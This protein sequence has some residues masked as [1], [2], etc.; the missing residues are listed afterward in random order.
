MRSATSGFPA[1]LLPSTFTISEQLNEAGLLGYANQIAAFWNANTGELQRRA[2]TEVFFD[3]PITLALQLQQAGDF[4]TALD[5]YRI[6]YALDLPPGNVPPEQLPAGAPPR[7]W[8]RIFP[9]LNAEKSIVTTYDQT[10]QWLLDNS[11]NP[12]QFAKQRA[13]AYTRFT[14]LA[15]VRCMLS[16]ADSE[17][18]T[19]SFESLPRAR[20][21]Y[22]NAREVLDMP[23][24]SLPPPD[25][26]VQMNPV[27]AAF[28]ANGRSKPF[29][30]AY[31]TQY[32]RHAAG[33][34]FAYCSAGNARLD[35]RLT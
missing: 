9:G 6:V 1:N 2:L 33:G 28:R 3:L 11:A 15:I 19:D 18:T 24:L 26:R 34:S 16:Y 12:H 30:T 35:R 25:K 7:E 29:Q 14:L 22:I 23:E 17:F 21:L 13:N 32:R 20:A 8:R 31:A 10:S 27:I 4:E 5:W